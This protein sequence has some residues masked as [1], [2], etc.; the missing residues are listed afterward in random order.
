VFNL[1]ANQFI[2]LNGYSM[3]SPDPLPGY[4]QMQTGGSS[5]VRGYTEGVQ[6]GDKGYNLNAEYRYPI[7]GLDRIAPKVAKTLQGAAFV[8]FAQVFTDKNSTAYTATAR[9]RDKTTLMGT[10]V[11][12]RLAVNQYL[13]GFIDLGVGLMDRDTT[14]PRGMPGARAHFGV[15]SN[16]I[17]QTYKARG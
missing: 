15:R 8:D 11:G 5:S 10:G 9:G 1:P 7:W 6:F 14:E 12:L 17:P 16:L 3:I 13:E 2:I 4:E